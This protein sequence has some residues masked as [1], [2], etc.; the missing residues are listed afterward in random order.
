MTEVSCIVD[1]K[2]VLGE[3][4]VWDPKAGALY[5]VDIKG[6]KVLRHTPKSGK[7]EEWPMPE[8]ACSLA[9]REKGGLVVALY[10]GFRL[11]DP[12]TGRI[13]KIRDVA[14]DNPRIRMNDGK[15]DRKGRFWAGSID[16]ELTDPLGTFYRLDPDLSCHAMQEHVI[17][18]NGTAFSPDDKT[19]YFA[20]SGKETIWAY[21]LDIDSGRISNQRVFSGP[22]DAPGVPDGATVDAEGYL[23]SARWGGWCVVRYDPKGRIDRKIDLPLQQPTCPAF[24]GDKLDVMYMT[25]ARWRLSGADLAKQPF[26]GGLCVLDVGVR[27]LPEPYFKG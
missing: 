14:P 2:N 9:V 23:W 27:G 11:F 4:P 24:G 15:P 13:E 20:D 8:E 1:C 22:G 21:D 3:G 16:D 17:C 19:L 10:G 12:S 6:R 7:T 25:S 18:S 5:W 26:A